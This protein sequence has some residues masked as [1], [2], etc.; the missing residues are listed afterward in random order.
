MAS[1]RSPPCS[2]MIYNEINFSYFLVISHLNKFQNQ[3]ENAIGIDNVI[4]FYN[5]RMS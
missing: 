5:I 4:K 2:V 1:N 3:T